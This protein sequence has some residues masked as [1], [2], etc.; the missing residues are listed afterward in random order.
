MIEDLRSLVLYRR[1]QDISLNRE[2][3]RLHADLAQISPGYQ[4][5]ITARLTLPSALTKAIRLITKDRSVRADIA[6]RRVR[7]LRGL[8]KQ[9]AELN[10]RIG[11]LVAA[12]GTTLTDTE[13]NP[14]SQWQTAPPPSKPPR[15]GS[16]V[17]ASTGEATAA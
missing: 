3:N 2:A 16:C 15:N 17:T 1:E 12:S 14:D 7:T 4:T 13:P 9:I 10:R 8:I 6:R 5:K 11:Q